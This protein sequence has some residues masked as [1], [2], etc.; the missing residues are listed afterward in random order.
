MKQAY[1]FHL[2]NNPLFAF[3]GLWEHWQG[4]QGILES[5]A[6]ITTAANAVMRPVH[7]R[8]PVILAPESYAEWLEKGAADLLLPFTGG[9]ECIP[10]GP[11]VNNP[12]NDG[13]E[14]IEPAR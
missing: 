1:Y 3:A 5:C 8:M 13:R 2:Q 6:I 10:V 14:L 11:A 7:D 12:R 9:L 4:E